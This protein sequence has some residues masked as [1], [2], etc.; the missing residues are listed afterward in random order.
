LRTRQKSSHAA[1]AIMASVRLIFGGMDF[2]I[3]ARQLRTCG[4]L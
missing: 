4:G 3:A 2:S 1:R